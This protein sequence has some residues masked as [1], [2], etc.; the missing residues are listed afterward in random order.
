MSDIDAIFEKLDTDVPVQSIRQEIAALITKHLKQLQG[1]LGY[2]E[3]FHF[4]SAISA[5]A[6]NRNP[7]E[8]YKSSAWLRLCLV[9]IEKGFVP[10]NERN[11]NY[12][13]KDA[14]IEALTYEQLVEMLNETMKSD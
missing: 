1:A 11:E 2:W 7:A 5:L 9:N 14:Q 6:W 8:K 4:L 13:R 10:K 12:A 3:K